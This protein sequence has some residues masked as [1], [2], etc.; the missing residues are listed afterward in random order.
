MRL[1][2]FACAGGAIGTGARYLVYL[3]AGRI[4]GAASPYAGAV[5]TLTVN[6]VGSFL[7]GAVIEAVALRF[8]GSAEL[9]TLLATG[10]LGGFTTFSAF[11]MDFVHLLERGDTALGLL[12]VLASVAISILALGAG[13]MAT[14][15]LLG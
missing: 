2:L 12:Y 13:L 14:R 3:A 10:V 5:A 9:R 11:S 7:M 4:I 1:F 6:I 15:V 8:N